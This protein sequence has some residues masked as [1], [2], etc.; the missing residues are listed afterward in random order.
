MGAHR[1]DAALVREDEGAPRR[2]RKA[3]AS[4]RRA[5]TRDGGVEVP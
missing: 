1:E 2:A 4:G 5:R 3:G